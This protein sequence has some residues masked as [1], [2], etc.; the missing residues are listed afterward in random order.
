MDDACC[1]LDV[2][3]LQKC[4]YFQTKLDIQKRILTNLLQLIWH[5]LVSTTFII[6]H[7]IAIVGRLYN[8]Q[9]K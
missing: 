5:K 3:I 4:I 9:F 7:S 8:F 2:S 6:D 1:C